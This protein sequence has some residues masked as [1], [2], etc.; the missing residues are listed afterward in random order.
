M[1]VRILGVDLL[2]L[3]MSVDRPTEADMS[4]LLYGPSDELVVEP[5]A[6]PD[7]DFEPLK[8]AAE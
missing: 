2:T 5:P 8:W 3:L 6:V 7:S 4:W 1:I